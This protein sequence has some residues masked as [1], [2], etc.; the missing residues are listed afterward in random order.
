M[1]FVFLFL[2]YFTLYNNLYPSMLLHMA[3]F[4]SFLLLRY[5]AHIFIH[6]SVSDL[7]ILLL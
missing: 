7:T 3:L 2:I 5:I 4:H 1:V 6:S